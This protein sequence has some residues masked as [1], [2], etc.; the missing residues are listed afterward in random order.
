M[1][2]DVEPAADPNICW[3]VRP[4]NTRAAGTPRDAADQQAA[5]HSRRGCT[6]LT[7]AKAQIR[8]LPACGLG[9]HISKACLECAPGGSGEV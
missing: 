3:R 4:R 8:T 2:G 5:R 1:P 6:A 7:S 9:G